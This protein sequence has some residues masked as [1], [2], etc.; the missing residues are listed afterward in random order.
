MTAPSTDAVVERL[1]RFSRFE[2]PGHVEEQLYLE[3]P[4]GPLFATALDP[5]ATRREAAFA[6]C[7]S[8]AWEQFELHPL[9]LAFARAAADAGFPSLVPQARG[10]GDSGGPF[11]EVTPATHVRDAVAAAEL[12]GGRTGLAVIP[13]GARF[14][15]SVALA[16]AVRTGAP[17]VALWDPPERPARYFQALLRALQ[18]A[19]VSDEEGEVDVAAPPVADVK[20]ALEEGRTVDLF[21]YPLT[22]ACYAEGRAMDPLAGAERVPPRALIVTVNPG[23]RGSAQR[24]AA[25]LRDLGSDVRLAEAEGP[26]RGDF[27]LGIPRA[28]HLATHLETFRDVARRTLAWAG[29]A[30]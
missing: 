7:H 16:A 6:T 20:R 11:A 23:T 17:G 19:G 26:G 22:A 8:F 24:L 30:W 18:V 28:G 15:A 2:A 25:R 5:A 12:L 3:T 21:G 14:G 13:V 9:E 27:G 29:E 10:Y 1:R 4:A